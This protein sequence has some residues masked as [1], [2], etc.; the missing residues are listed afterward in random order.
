MILNRPAVLAWLLAMGPGSGPALAAGDENAE[1][2]RFN[3]D[4]RPILSDRCFACHGPDDGARKAGLRLDLAEEAT[5]EV[6]GDATGRRYIFPGAPERSEILRRISSHDPEERMPPPEAKLEVSGEETER[7]RRWIAE[8][9]SFESHWAFIPLP[10]STPE[11]GIEDPW[12]RNPIDRF[13]LRRLRE[14]G[15]TPAPEAAPEILLRRVS[16][17]LTGLPPAPAALD[18]YLKEDP[19]ERYTRA[20]RRLLASR[21]YGER[22]AVDWLDAARYADT[23]GYQADVYRPVWPWRDWVARAFNEN[24]PYDAFLTFQ[25]A[26][27]LLP[28]A[29]RDQRLATAFNRHHRQTN[30]GGSV[31]EEF[32]IEYVADRTH[33]FGTVFAGLTLECARCHDHKYD[34]VTQEDYY[35]L[36]AFFNSIDESGLY[37]HFTSA[38]P[39]PAL[40]LTTPEEDRR[41]AEAE[42]RVREKEGTLQ[43]QGGLRGAAFADWLAEASG[44]PSMP[45]L[46]GAWDFEEAPAE[47]GYANHADPSKP[48]KATDGP[49]EVEGRRGRGLLLSGEN[50]VEFRGAG[51]F[52]R[53]DP[54]TLALWMRAPERME[55]AVVLHRSRSWTDAGSQ[56]YQLLLEEGRLSW[57]LVHFWPG[58]AISVQT[59]EDF[60]VD[61]WTQVTVSYDGSSRAEG[62]CIFIDGAPA[63][64]ETLRDGLTR[65]ITGGG[66][67]VLTAGQRFRD[68][69]FKG[70]AIDEVRV[71][72]RAVSR[73]EAAALAA[74]GE[75][76]AGPA[77]TELWREFYL[78]AVDPE[79]ARLR[80]ELET[81]RRELARLR[82]STAEIMTMEELPVPRPAYVLRRG[83]YEAPGELVERGV[84]E[85]IFG[86][87]ADLPR[88]RLGLARWMLDPRHPL[89][90]RVAVNRLWQTCFGQGLV[91]TPDNFGIQ[92]A[93][94]SHP[95]LLDWLARRFVDSGWDVKG[96]LELMMSSATYRQRSSASPELREKDPGNVLLARGPSSRL[97]AEMLRDGALFVGGIL[98]DRPGGPPVH[99]YQPAGLWE[100]KSGAAYPQDQGEG[101]FRRSLYTIWKRTS[102]PPS[103]LTFDAAKREVC[104]VRRERTGSPLQALVLL[105]DPQFVEAARG[106]G[107]RILREGGPTLESRLIYGFRLAT[108]RHPDERE[109]R[110][111][112]EIYED[113]RARFS[114]DEEGARA[115]LSVGTRP[116]DLN[117]EAE[118]LAAAAAVGQALLNLDAAVVKR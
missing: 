115:Y 83:S 65:S 12:I 44:P 36:S 62:L 35:R 38:T 102:P 23:Y 112:A 94:P 64:V 51:E 69:G 74:G 8:G 15:W 5:R 73:L 103:M 116:V 32:R 25:L 113:Q 13:I 50:N 78:A 114:T 101:L 34:P 26:G 28:G 42:Q 86:W 53:C 76:D 77:D 97:P 2:L 92:G 104:V 98:V 11:P 108:S 10:E 84:P 93:S 31:E 109:R 105:N 27:D 96:M 45:G 43:E 19:A 118:D 68:R 1:P 17:D 95:D 91:E 56:G 58:N 4:I 33:T 30:E 106:L 40:A 110:I 61:R 55:R 46:T 16:Y 21:Q 107:E 89:T 90:A 57:S 88:D 81:A 63:R 37:S 41:L 80:A 20:L 7:L 18:A 47:G 39:T 60:P 52:D 100:E 48:A 67:L 99:P 111:L 85:A 6:E 3:R 79:A 9:A 29:T 82:D 24:L 75:W 54:F 87:P 70:G 59:E 72:D 14:E 71:F 22:M 117:F 66:G 49:A